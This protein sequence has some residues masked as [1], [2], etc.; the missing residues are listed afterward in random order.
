MDGMDSQ[1][2]IIGCDT[3]EDLDFDKK[4]I[5]KQCEYAEDV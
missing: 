5:L 4:E 3:T 1:G 2:G